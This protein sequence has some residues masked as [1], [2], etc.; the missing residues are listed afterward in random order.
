MRA[1]SGVSRLLADRE[2]ELGEADLAVAAVGA[3]TGRSNREAVAVLE[4]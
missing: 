2:L 3:L 4:S 1:T